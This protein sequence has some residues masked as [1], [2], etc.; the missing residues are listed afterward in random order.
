[1]RLE[2]GKR[3]KLI[4][5]KK[6]ITQS[7]LGEKLGIQFQHVSKYERGETV[8]T[9]ENLIKLTEIFDVNINWFLTGKGKMFLSPV[10]YSNEKDGPLSLVHDND[11][12][13]QLEEIIEELRNDAELKDLIYDYVQNYRKLRVTTS[14]LQGRID[15]MK[16]KL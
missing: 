9:W 6:G 14:K 11:S 1:M 10:T 5:N 2:I 16:Q 3:L 7:E 4:R 8:P 12:D 15:Q 13:E